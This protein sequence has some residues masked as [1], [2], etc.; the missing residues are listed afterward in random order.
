MTRRDEYGRTQL[1]YAALDGTI[2]E[3]RLPI[4]ENEDVN[5]RDK[6]KWAPMHFAEQ[7]GRADIVALLLEAGAQ[8]DA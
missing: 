5:D 3:V 8:V 1:H 6:Q 7:M 4:E 2:D